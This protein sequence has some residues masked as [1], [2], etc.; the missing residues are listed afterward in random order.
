MSVVRITSGVLAGS[1]RSTVWA[2]TITRKAPPVPVLLSWQ[3]APEQVFVEETPFW[4]MGNCSRKIGKMHF[5]KYGN[6][7]V[8]PPVTP[9]FVTLP[10]LLSGSPP[11]PQLA[12]SAT[13]ATA[14]ESAPRRR[15]IFE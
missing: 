10:G 2:A 12:S 9:G 8:A 13:P 15:N 14:L 5:W 7:S 4:T 11:P 3:P 1:V 6:A